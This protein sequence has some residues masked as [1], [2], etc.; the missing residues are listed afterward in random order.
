MDAAQQGAGESLAAKQ[1]E[2]AAALRDA[3]E[4]E[5]RLK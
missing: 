2:L 4:V 3:E 5:P 1:H